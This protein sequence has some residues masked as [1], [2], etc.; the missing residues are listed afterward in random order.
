MQEKARKSITKREITNL[1]KKFTK[2]LLPLKSIDEVVSLV[3]KL[4]PDAEEINSELFDER[5]SNE[6][7]VWFI[8]PR[9]YTGAH[10]LSEYKKAVDDFAGLL[11]SGES[12][13]I[14]ISREEGVY[15]I[16]AYAFFKYNT[17]WDSE[18]YGDLEIKNEVINI[19]LDNRKAEI[20]NL[21]KDIVGLSSGT[22]SNLI[23][24]E[25]IGEA[26]SLYILIDEV[27]KRFVEFTSN[28]IQS[29][30]VV[31]I[32]WSDAWYKFK[33]ENSISEIA[34]SLGLDDS[35]VKP[36]YKEWLDANNKL[37]ELKQELSSLLNLDDINFND[38]D[39]DSKIKLAHAYSLSVL[40]KKCD[41]DEK[42]Y[43]DKISLET[44][45][46]V[47]VGE[48]TDDFYDKYSKS[49]LEILKSM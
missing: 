35:K 28:Y 42:E 45:P 1:I 40:K 12:I 4:V 43:I 34:Y 16:K 2:E 23:S 30:S 18:N 47:L 15:S 10:N 48:Y 44:I 24:K 7:S 19:P 20:D 32:D 22:I 11:S 41:R 13:T 14:D 27:Q 21:I 38:L 46:K 33:K 3:E 39:T 5:Y 36:N 25:K 8:I 29:T 9:N 6:F 49:G 26:S 17:P 31:P 37:L